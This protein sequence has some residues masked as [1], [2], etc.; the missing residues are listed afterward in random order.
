M[1]TLAGAWQARIT[2]VAR[3]WQARITPFV[4]EH[5]RLLVGAKSVNKPTHQQVAVQ[6]AVV[7]CD[8]CV[9][10]SGQQGVLRGQPKKVVGCAEG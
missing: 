7:I 10:M 2:T 1:T 6:Q 8:G 3:A 5:G 4:R 9:G